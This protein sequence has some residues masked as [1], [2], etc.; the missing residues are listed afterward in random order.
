MKLRDLPR[1][2]GEILS[3]FITIDN[4]IS[5]IISKHYLGDSPTSQTQINK[6]TDFLVNVLGNDQFTFALKRNILIHI[7]KKENLNE[8]LIEELGR[9]NNL[10]NIFSHRTWLTNENP[11]VPESEIYYQNPKFP[12]DRTKNIPAEDLKNEY[13][14]L[15]P[16]VIQ[17]LMDLAEKQGYVFPP[18]LPRI[19]QLVNKDG[20]VYYVGNGVLLGIPDIETFNSWHYR[21]ENVLPI[22]NEE[23]ALPQGG[24]IPTKLEGYDNPLHQIAASGINEVGG[25][26]NE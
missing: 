22:S 17:W 25:D 6:E 8:S 21:F 15:W 5:M 9:L 16:D 23:R 20:T 18:P 10:R 19:G 1:E 11:Q 12:W 24:N 2:R 7:L 26:N 14:S 3:T 13:N 4:A